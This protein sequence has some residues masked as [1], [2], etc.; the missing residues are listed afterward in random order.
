MK[1]NLLFSVLCIFFSSCQV[2]F[3][4]IIKYSPELVKELNYAL[5][6]N[7]MEKKKEITY[8]YG[9]K[10]P[11]VFDKETIFIPCKI[12]DV[13]H[14]VL[15]N[16]SELY[17]RF[18]E[19][20]PGNV[21]F[22]KTCKTVKERTIIRGVTIK[23]GLNYYHIESDFF[24]FKQYVG[25]LFSVSNDSIIPKCMSENNKNRFNLGVDAF[26]KWKDVML[27][28]FSDTSITLLDSAAIYDTTGFTSVKAMSTCIGPMIYLTVDGIEYTFLFHTE[29][30]TFLSMP[31]YEQVYSRN[32]TFY[33]LYSNSPYEKHKKEQ[34]VSIVGCRMGDA[35]KIVIDTSIIQQT[36]T[37]TMGDMD[38]I[39]GAILYSKN[40]SRPVMG[41]AFIAN[42]DWIIDLNKEK[43]YAKKIK[44]TQYANP[45]SSY[46]QV[47]VF[48]TTLQISLLPVGETKYQLFSIID[49][50]NGEKVNMDNICQM[51]ELLNKAN[52]FKENQ[53]VV[54]PLPSTIRL[55]D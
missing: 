33:Y 20:I 18:E 55:K 24:D 2:S 29:S 23:K 13:T 42:F 43:M 22:P 48:D 35:S 54:L 19:Q 53:I 44:D 10:F 17:A 37:I 50:V 21:E 16:T 3:W 45:Y 4:T 14:L 8:Y 30:E 41:M 49:S 39:A 52:G 26:P 36:N 7:R 15:Y 12:N 28:S 34:D 38:S 47:N 27:L 1:K 9:K 6:E 31:R 11:F 40:V 46:Y 51:K 5:K 32:N 25:R